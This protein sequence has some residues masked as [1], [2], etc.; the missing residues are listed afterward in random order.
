MSYGKIE[1]NENGL[2]KCEIC[3]EHY[4]R[5]EKTM[6]NIGR[7]DKAMTFGTT[8]LRKEDPALIF[9]SKN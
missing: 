2:P 4:H 5:V 3:G 9:K 1:Y 8:L 7:G 6:S